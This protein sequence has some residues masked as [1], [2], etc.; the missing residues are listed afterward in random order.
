MTAVRILHMNEPLRDALQSKRMP[1]TYFLQIPLEA[2][3]G[4]QIICK[5]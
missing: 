2:A 3:R 1:K 4:D 5:Y